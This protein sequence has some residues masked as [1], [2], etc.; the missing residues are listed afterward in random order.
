MTIQ[1]LNTVLHDGTR[2]PAYEIVSGLP[3]A[4]EQALIASGA[5]RVY[6][7]EAASAPAA[8]KEPE[9][10]AP[11]VGNAASASEAAPAAETGKAKVAK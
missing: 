10:E 3:D 1:M 8:P 11:E 7:L 4:V 6:S 2:I 5:A 9:P